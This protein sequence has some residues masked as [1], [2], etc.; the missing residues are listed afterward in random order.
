MSA[1]KLT[2][3]SLDI[4]CVFDFDGSPSCAISVPP[5]KLSS[6]GY[7]FFAWLRLESEEFQQRD[8]FSGLLRFVMSQAYDSP[9]SLLNESGDGVV[10]SFTVSSVVATIYYSGTVASRTVQFTFEPFKVGIIL[11]PNSLFQV[12]SLR[13]RSH[14]SLFRPKRAQVL[15]R[16]HFD[17][18]R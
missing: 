1:L 15:C 10:L 17:R 13:V 14:F 5:F 8:I 18:P 9:S 11:Q 7:S 12:V 4:H 3:K 16:R 6:A 2:T